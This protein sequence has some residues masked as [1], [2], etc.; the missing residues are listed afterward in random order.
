MNIVSI[1]IIIKIIINIFLQP[2]EVN[3]SL[4]KNNNNISNKTSI[5]YNIMLYKCD[6]CY[7]YFISREELLIHLKIYHP[8][9]YADIQAL[10]EEMKEKFYKRLL[11]N[12]DY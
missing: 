7:G 1:L 12:Y 5:N 2:Y 4:I 10:T 9:E 6:I 3:Y 8:E 11:S